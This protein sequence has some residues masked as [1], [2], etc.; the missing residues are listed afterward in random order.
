MCLHAVARHIDLHRPK[1][2]HYSRYCTG[3]DAIEYGLGLK[4]HPNHATAFFD[5][6]EGSFLEVKDKIV[7][8]NHV[9]GA[10][11]GLLFMPAYRARFFNRPLTSQQLKTIHF[12]IID[13]LANFDGRFDPKHRGN[14]EGYRTELIAMA[15]FARIRR[16]EWLAFM[17]TP[18]EEHSLYFKFNNDCHVIVNATKV[19]IQVKRKS[20]RSYAPYVAMVRFYDI[21][22]QVNAWRRPYIVQ[23]W[24]KKRKLAS[25]PEPLNYKS[26][27]QLLI[28]ETKGKLQPGDLTLLNAASA[29]AAAEVLEKYRLIVDRGDTIPLDDTEEAA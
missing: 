19:P 13:L 25:V 10:E 1:Q 2:D 15:L 4:E 6:G 16:T 24:G 20:G 28:D 17:S 29:Y 27:T 14:M 3:W 26:F 22:E 12:G 18:R 9:I 11:I 21:M 23:D 7:S 8:P 5:Y